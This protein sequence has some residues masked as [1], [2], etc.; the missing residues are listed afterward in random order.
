MACEEFPFG[1]FLIKQVVVELAAE[2]P[3]MENF[4]RSLPCRVFPKH[5][6]TPHNEDGLSRGAYRRCLLITLPAWLRQQDAAIPWK[7]SFCYWRSLSLIA[8]YLARHYLASH[9]RI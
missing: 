3:N 8:T 6:W 4:A 2:F 1:N 7:R 9:L 5:C